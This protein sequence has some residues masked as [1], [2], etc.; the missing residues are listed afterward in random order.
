[1]ILILASSISNPALLKELNNAFKSR[2]SVKEEDDEIDGDRINNDDKPS[3]S[4]RSER[5]KTM[6]SSSREVG[7]SQVMQYLFEECD[8][9]NIQVQFS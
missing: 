4:R 8:S 6:E 5:C 1:M 3:Q 7:L 2:E 9:C